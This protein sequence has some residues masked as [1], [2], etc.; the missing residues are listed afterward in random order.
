[1]NY[2]ISDMELC[3]I[4]E[5]A[6]LFVSVFNSEPWNDSWT[7]ETALIRIEN[8]MRTNTFIG[9]AI[10]FE[11]NL[12]GIIWGQKEQYY[13]GMH[14][15]IQEFCVKTGEQNKGYGSALLQALE[16]ELSE[17]GIVNIYLITSKGEK[18]EDYY[19]RRGFVTSDQ[20]ILMTNN[21]F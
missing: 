12:K 16:N 3:R 9:K 5:Y 8:M 11:D 7:K 21:S 1:M 2:K 20:M 17:I 19:S 18:T 4:T 15:Q 13:N 6:E 14:F 10:Y